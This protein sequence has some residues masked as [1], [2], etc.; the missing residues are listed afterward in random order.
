MYYVNQFYKKNLKIL[1]I[2]TNYQ[3]IKIK[4]KYFSLAHSIN[5]TPGNIT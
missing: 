1:K 3:L 2:F 4:I 5:T